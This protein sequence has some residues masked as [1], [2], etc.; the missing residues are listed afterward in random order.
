ML[1]GNPRWPPLKIEPYWKR[2]KKTIF[3]ETR[4]LIESKLFIDNYFVVPCKLVNF[5]VDQKYSSW[6]KSQDIV[7]LYRYE[8]N[9]FFPKL[10]TS[11]NQNSA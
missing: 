11:I 10:E 7:E 8:L 6:S 4:K 3:I 1:I 2:K 5:C 9:D